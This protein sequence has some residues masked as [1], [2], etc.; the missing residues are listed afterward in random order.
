MRVLLTGASGFLGSYV[1]ESLERCGAEVVVLGR[2]PPRRSAE[3]IELDLL[4]V[5]D[6]RPWLREANATHLLHLAWY[7]EHGKYWSSPLNLRW[8]DATVRLVE[9]FCE[10]GGCRVV[11]AGTCAEYDWR[12]SYCQEESTP[13]APATLYGVAKDVAR[14]LVMAV[15]AKYKVSCGWGRVFIPFG[16]RESVE[17]LIPSLVDVF[18]G[19]RPPFGVNARAYRDFLHASDVANGLVR[20]L[21]QDSNEVYN[22]SSG[23]PT[24]L[25]EIVL[26]LADLLDADPNPILD[27]TSERS[28]EPLI[29]LGDSLK[30]RSI[31]WSPMLD[32]RQGLKKTLCGDSE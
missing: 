19:G 22:V 7:A 30:L 13:C 27:L 20:L 2:T 14:R 15:C 17:R 6:F 29:L 1:Q 28:G 24:R 31:G 16:N 12:Y 4:S 21:S 26:A 11:A 10:S 25:S 5:T 32:L 18:K 9:G 23:E 3:F 8:V